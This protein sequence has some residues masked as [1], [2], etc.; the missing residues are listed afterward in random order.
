MVLAIHGD[1]RASRSSEKPDDGEML[2]L[3]E[4]RAADGAQVPAE[5]CGAIIARTLTAYSETQRAFRRPRSS[6]LPLGLQAA[7]QLGLVRVSSS[8]PKIRLFEESRIATKTLVAAGTSMTRP[9]GP[10]EGSAPARSAQIQCPRHLRLRRQGCSPKC[11]PSRA[12]PNSTGRPTDAE[13]W[14]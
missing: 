10:V 11:C 7:A 8:S 12:E 6:A 2:C 14:R 9:Q 4:I 1:C 5:I 3:V 13:G